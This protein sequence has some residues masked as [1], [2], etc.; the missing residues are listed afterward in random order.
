MI[1]RDS[2]TPRA[3]PVP[4]A[5]AADPKA[6]NCGCACHE[7]RE[8]RSAAADGRL[9]QPPP[10]G[11]RSSGVAHLPQEKF[12]RR[13]SALSGL[14]HPSSFLQAPTYS[15]P[16]VAGAGFV[17]GTATTG[18]LR[19][20]GCFCGRHRCTR[21][22]KAS[23]PKDGNFGPTDGDMVQCCRPAWRGYSRYILRYPLF[24]LV[25]A[26]RSKLPLE[27][28]NSIRTVV[29]QCSLRAVTV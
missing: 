12:Q 8:P 4:E 25:T 3:T 13:F 28:M 7:T 20:T 27:S 23:G 1:K 5:G 22:T 29:I 14:L 17:T 11:R 19:S 18:C 24:L 10:I 21:P 26:D 6:P 9:A 2:V 16:V 15:R